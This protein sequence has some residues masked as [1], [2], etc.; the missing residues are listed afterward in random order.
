[1]EYC[2]GNLE[3]YIAGRSPLSER[4]LTMVEV[5]SVM[6]DIA[7]GVEFI[8]AHG[9]VHR[10]LKPQNSSSCRRLRLTTQFF[11]LKT[12]MFGRLRTLA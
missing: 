8:H 10:D 12:L 6:I 5:W 1:M 2:D 11:I 7:K 4:P 3:E 9:E